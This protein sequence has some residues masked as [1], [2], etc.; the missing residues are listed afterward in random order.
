MRSPTSIRCGCNYHNDPWRLYCGGC[1]NQLGP[2]CARCRFVNPG[3][4][5]FCGGCGSPIETRAVAGGRPEPVR[6]KAAQ[7]ATVPIEIDDVLSET[8]T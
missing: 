7:H 8:S 6:A 5:R 1:G 4:D 3:V 2:A